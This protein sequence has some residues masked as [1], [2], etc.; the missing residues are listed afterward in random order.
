MNWKSIIARLGLKLAEHLVEGGLLFLIGGLKRGIKRLRK[1][2]KRLR[3]KLGRIEPNTPKHQRA[4]RRLKWYE[5]RVQLR[6]KALAWCRE[7]RSTITEKWARELLWEA[8]NVPHIG[9]TMAAWSEAI[10]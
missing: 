8:Q 1:K 6:R 10:E 9:E 2:C 3:K 7:K 5:W 4:L